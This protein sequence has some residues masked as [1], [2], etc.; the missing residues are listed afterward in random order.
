MLIFTMNDGTARDSP[1]NPNL[2]ILNLKLHLE[3][4]TLEKAL[5]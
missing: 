3:M 1:F 5:K 4:N 2:G